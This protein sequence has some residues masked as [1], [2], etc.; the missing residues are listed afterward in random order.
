MRNTS[1]EYV[2]NSYIGFN[3]EKCGKKIEGY[4]TFV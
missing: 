2:V 4:K 1:V 3:K